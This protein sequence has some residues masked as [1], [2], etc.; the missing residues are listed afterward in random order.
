MPSADAGCRTQPRQPSPGGVRGVVYFSGLVGRDVIPESAMT[1]SVF[2][3]VA[4]LGYRRA[5][6]RM[7]PPSL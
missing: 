3:V 5:E 4:V 1:Y 7:G 2:R 6:A